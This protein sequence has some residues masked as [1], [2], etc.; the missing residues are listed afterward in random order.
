MV[1]ARTLSL[2]ELRPQ[3]DEA[4]TG[5][6]EWLDG[7][8]FAGWDPYDALN[9]P[10]LRALSL[11]LK[12]PRIAF[13]QALRRL[14]VNLRPVLGIKRSY[15]PKGL[16]LF[17]GASARRLSATGDPRHRDRVHTLVQ[18]LR[19]LRRGRG[20]GYPFPW[21]SRAFFVPRWTP[22]IVNTSFVAHALMD[23]SDACGEESWF[24]LAREACDF[25]LFD[26]NRH[27]E[28]D[29]LCFS[30]TPIDS[31]K[32]HN[33]NMLGAA[34]LARVGARTGEEELLE[35]A[36]RATRYLLK[37]QRPDGSWW[38]AEPEYQH[39]IDSFHTGF[40]LEA[41]ACV[42]R[43]A[44]EIG[45]AG[46][47]GTEPG[48]TEPEGACALARG[49]RFFLDHFYEAD[50]APKYFHD[51]RGPLDIHGPTQGF[52]TMAELWDVQS[53]EDLL[54][55]SAT[56]FLTRM[57]APEG[58]FYYRVGRRPNRIPYMR[59]GQAWAYHGLV[60]LQEF[61]RANPASRADG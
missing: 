22:T 53:A 49:H 31:L 29:A 33:A 28:G 27:E 32:V 56:W 39:W 19:E 43:Y 40:N 6:E 1:L 3:V 55:R 59:W 44:G 20:W 8:G 41:L 18:K 17:L 23:A 38:Y 21:Q 10:V 16:G 42:L 36:R 26:L 52:V 57:R 47:E 51:R 11:G 37:Y 2:A 45:G 9:S 4:V 5:L 15:N 34:L 60:R 7:Y 30:Y 50:G 46:P 61:L 48:G 24:Q 25:V 35:A 54:A 14:P 58:Y 13:T 12:Y